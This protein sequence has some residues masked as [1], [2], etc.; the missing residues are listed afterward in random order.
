MLKRIVLTAAS[1]A[2][3]ATGLAAGAAPAQ[4]ALRDCPSGNFCFW[5]NS[6]YQGARAD[7]F[8]SDRNLA[9]NLF[10]DGPGTANGFNVQVEDNAASVANRTGS[11]A[12]IY[13]WRNCN[14][15]GGASAVQAGD[16]RTLGALKNKV[17]S[18][19]LTSTGICLSA[20]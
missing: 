13:N 1:A 10:D 8:Y 2:A 12:V 5:F 16:E 20:P 9:D 3:V 15:D 6:D 19:S 11:V 4:A 18:V 14:Q 17:S 7:F